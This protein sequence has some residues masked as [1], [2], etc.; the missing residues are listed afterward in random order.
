MVSRSI[1]VETTPL[2]IRMEPFTC[3]SPDRR[4]SRIGLPRLIQV[5]LV[6]AP[7]AGAIRADIPWPEVERRCARENARL[8]ARPQGHAGEYFVV[9][10]LY[11]TPMES[12]F[13]AERGFDATPIPPPR[14]ARPKA[15]PRFL[16]RGEKGRS[17]PDYETCSMGGTTFA[18]TADVP[19]GMPVSHPLRTRRS[20]R[21]P[22]FRGGT[23]K[24]SRPAFRRRYRNEQPP[25]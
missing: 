8:A 24:S 21:R 5:L 20:P 3:R 18:T 17:R 15:S 14:I 12:G 4:T 6:L 2:R 16:A 22:L 23:S 25:P 9:C 1:S 19:I 13:T 11:Y 7:V 10:T